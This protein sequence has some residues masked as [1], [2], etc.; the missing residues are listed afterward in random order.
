L[1]SRERTQ[2]VQPPNGKGPSERDGF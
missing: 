2:D 1:R